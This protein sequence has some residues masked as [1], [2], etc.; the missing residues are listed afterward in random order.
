MTEAP[1]SETRTSPVSSKLAP[2]DTLKDRYGGEIP[3]DILDLC[4]LASRQIKTYIE[5]NDDTFGNQRIDMVRLKIQAMLIDLAAEV[6]RVDRTTEGPCFFGAVIER[7]PLP[8]ELRTSRKPP[9]LM[10]Q[11]QVLRVRR[12]GHRN[13]RH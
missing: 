8:P 1:N 6:V 3:L 2:M 9:P 5:T 11:L 10:R 13:G 4:Y 7:K 12:N